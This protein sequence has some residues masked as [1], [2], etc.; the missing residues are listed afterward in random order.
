MAISWKR[1]VVERNGI[2]IW[3]LWV[4]RGIAESCGGV[5]ELKGKVRVRDKVNLAISWKRSVV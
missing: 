1:S 4:K 3:T 2:K 5:S